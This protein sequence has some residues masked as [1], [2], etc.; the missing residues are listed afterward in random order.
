[1]S[2]RWLNLSLI[3]TYSNMQSGGLPVYTAATNPMTTKYVLSSDDLAGSIDY[4]F[5]ASVGGWVRC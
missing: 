2:E 4:R 3:L 5:H 1:M